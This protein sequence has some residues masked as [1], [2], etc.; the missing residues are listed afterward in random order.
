LNL[1]KID[2]FVG[3]FNYV[4]KMKSTKPIKKSLIYISIITVSLVAVVMIIS[5]G[6][7]QKTTNN[8]VYDD[9]NLVPANRVG[10]LLGTSKL[11]SNGKP[12][13]YFT[14]RIDAAVQLINVGKIKFV[15]ISGDN[16]RKDYNEP[17]DM[18]DALM[19]RGL[20]EN[21]IFLD[22]AGFRTYDSVYRMNAIF[23]QS[24][25]TIISQEFH[26]RRALYIA[27][28]LK[29]NAVAY[30]AKDV[31]KYFGIKTQVREFFSRVKM[32]LD[33]AFGKKPKFL[34]EKIK[35]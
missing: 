20:P 22:Y 9:A 29:I 25:F 15:V 13:Q 23:G 11:L 32:F 7:I 33:L 8:Y 21:R 24:S 3:T 10:L 2:I 5:Y 26:N 34:G 35:I 1:Q 17:Q 19:E 30:N 28:S 16:R 31:T 27:N 18:K 12:N 6:I 14:Y 4:N